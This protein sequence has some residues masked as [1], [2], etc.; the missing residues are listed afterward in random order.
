M[1]MVEGK[2]KAV[3]ANIEY[4]RKSNTKSM[5]DKR[6]IV[7]KL[8]SFENNQRGYFSSQTALENGDKLVSVVVPATSSKVKDMDFEILVLPNLS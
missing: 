6:K 3:N 4:K 1:D 7:T 8:L 5:H 2:L